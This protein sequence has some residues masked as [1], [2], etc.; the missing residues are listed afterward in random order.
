MTDLLSIA[1]SESAAIGSIT[2]FFVG[3]SCWASK[4]DQGNCCS[5]QK[6]S[7]N[8]ASKNDRVSHKRMWQP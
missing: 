7:H 2:V 8:A 1:L 5:Q 6:T 3:Y 4:H